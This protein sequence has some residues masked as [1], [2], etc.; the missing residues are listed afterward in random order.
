MSD[1]QHASQEHHHADHDHDHA[2]DHPH[3]HPHADAHDHPHDHPH[4]DAHDHAHGSGVMGWFQHLITPH[5]HDHTKTAQDAALSAS[6]RGIWAVKV[7]F[8]ALMVTALLQVGIVAATGSVALLADTVHNFSDAL[9][10]LPLW[11]AFTLSRRRADRRYTYGYARA[12]DLAGALIV[13]MIF[14]SALVVLYES[15]QKFI[16]PQPIHS[17]GLVA[18]AAVIGFVGNELVALFRIRV[19]REIGSAALEADGMHAR[20]DGLTSLAVLVGALGVWLGFPL[21]DPLVGVLIG[22]MILVI[23]R[24]SAREMWYRMMDATDPQIVQ[25]IERLA[26]EVQGVEGVHAVRARWLGHRIHAELHLEVYHAMPTIESHRIV[27]EVR[28]TLFHALPMLSEATVHVDP[29]GPDC[30]DPHALTDHH[31]RAL[32]Y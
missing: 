15:Y 32:A 22:V 8:A 29:C 16:N 27:E 23:V 18:L 1:S 28:H 4:A 21:A 3:D 13:G 2:H 17:L 14:F 31:N 7:S 6:E 26:R 20:V 10:A 12:E 9:T 24:D 11:L 25:N 30:D 19:G 5:S